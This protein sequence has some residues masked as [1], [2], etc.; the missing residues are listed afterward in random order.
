MIRRLV[1]GRYATRLAVACMAWLAMASAHAH[2]HAW[3]EV[4]STL[5]FSSTGM[6]MA[7]D[8]EWLFDELYTGF[9]IEDLADG[10]PVTQP[11][12]DG[13]G[14]KVIENLTPFG[15]FTEVTAGGKAVKLAPVTEFRSE[16]VGERLKLRFT[17][18]LAQPVDPVAV[19]LRVS[20]YDPTYFIEMRHPDPAA[21]TLRDAPA[22]CR[23]R[24]ERPKPSAAL[25]SRA[26]S[27]DRGAAPD[28]TMGKQF[29]EIVVVACG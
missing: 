22:A 23:T 29:A 6:V 2:P 1:G 7:I 25:Q 11:V 4:R 21:A 10:K 5:V 26:L 27:M 19:P 9:V 20:V 16:M 17:A 28:N 13:F 3:I 12:V 24:L 18:P 15:Y 14:A 8:E